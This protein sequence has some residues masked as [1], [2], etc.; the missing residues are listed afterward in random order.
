MSLDEFVYYILTVLLLLYTTI[1]RAGYDAH[2]LREVV[3][4]P[5]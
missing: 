5:S 3:C 4:G 1:R 2:T